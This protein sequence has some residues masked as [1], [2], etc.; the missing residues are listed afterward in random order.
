MGLLILIGAWVPG[1]FGDPGAQISLFGD[2]LQIGMNILISIFGLTM[3]LM[4]WMD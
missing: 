1:V 2:Q 3:L 4:P